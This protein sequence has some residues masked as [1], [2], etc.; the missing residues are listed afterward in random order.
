MRMISCKMA[1]DTLTQLYV[2]YLLIRI[3]LFM[4]AHKVKRTLL[5]IITNRNGQ[6]V[7]I[8]QV[9]YMK[10]SDNLNHAQNILRLF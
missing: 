3:Y 6:T 9:C 8:F 5:D 4:K 10:N 7:R 1:E 2:Q